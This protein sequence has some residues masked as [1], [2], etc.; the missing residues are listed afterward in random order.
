MGDPA[1]APDRI[2]VFETH[3]AR[4]G[5]PWIPVMGEYHFSRDCPERWREEL[6]KMRSGGVT[7]VATYV[8]W[9]LH[10]EH[11]GQV[12]WDG[13]RDLRRFIAT[14]RD[15]GLEV[16]VRV[17]PWAHGETRNG[18]F[19]DWLQELPVAHRTDDPAYL[20]IVRE[21][22]R[23][24]AA[25]LHG[26]LHEDGGPVIGIQV[27]NEIYDQPEHVRTLRRM[28]EDLGI[29]APL[30]TA[31]GWGGAALPE[32]EVLPVYAGY[33]DGF[34][35]ESTTGWPDFGRT[36]FVFSDVRD[37]LSVGADLRATP[38]PEQALRADSDP[39]PYATCELGGGMTVAYHRRPFVDAEDVAALALTKIGSGSSWQGYYLFHGGLHA[40]GELSTTQESQATGY[41]NDVP[42]RDYDFFAPIGAAGRQRAHFHALRRQHLMLAQYAP[43]IAPFRPVIPSQDPVR[44]AVRGAGERAWLFV[45]NHQPAAEPLGAVEDVQFSVAFGGRTVLVPTRPVTLDPGFSAVWPVRQPLGDVAS[46]TVT[47]QP[48]TEVNGPEGPVVFLHAADGVPPQF[49]L[50]GV[51]ESEIR[52]AA[53]VVDGDLLLATPQAPP[54]IGCEI[55][56]GETTFV[57]LDDAA[58]SG[59][60]KGEIDGRE[61]VVIWCGTGWFDGSFHV[62][63]PEG[64]EKLYAWPPLEEDTNPPAGVL[65]PSRV[66]ADPR[67]ALE[68]S[69]PA[70]PNAPTA[71][72]RT[73][74]SAGRLS[75]PDDVD[76]AGVEPVRIDVPGDAFDGVDRAILEIDWIGDVLRV[77]AGDVL[78]A[79]QFWS[80][81][82]FEVDI[83]PSREEVLASGL[84]IV[85]FAWDPSAGIHVDPRVRPSGSDPVLEIR[86]AR[87]RSERIREIR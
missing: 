33:S 38:A 6:A 40:M 72:V 49:Q 87:I 67:S 82:I 79:D 70:F 20:A 17:G 74:G 30:W 60:W 78:L 41:P 66:A 58:A 48:I 22:F 56:V 28:A 37:D 75:A 62:V 77:Y 50:E 16:M 2:E 42:V 85:A 1:D 44:W 80:G 15:V 24:I 86:H 29:R 54:G 5:A 23:E 13:A 63:A 21:W 52:G 46:V 59:L 45:G 9:I 10:E 71:P 65:R 57:L 3:L 25:Q 55:R 81:R 34:W 4:G 53:T 12:R 32:G 61:T 11:R 19:P 8:L 76:F 18:G 83:T 64:E 47:A 35:E 26:L 7:V 73:G 84:R 68:L 36:H 39:W 27:E 14:A 43:S 51:A 31:T 69:V